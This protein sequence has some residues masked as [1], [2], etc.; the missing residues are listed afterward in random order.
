[1]G[2]LQQQ[3]V[4]ADASWDVIEA[5]QIGI[6][7]D[8]PVQRVVTD[9]RI[10]KD[11]AEPVRAL[12]AERSPV[13][14]ELYMAR[15]LELVEKNSGVAPAAREVARGATIGGTGPGT[16]ADRRSRERTSGP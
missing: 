8:R 13:P 12:K 6:G 4:H 7:G 10:Q 2:A 1:V 5:Q 9:G 3:P 14:D 16:A 11:A 15:L